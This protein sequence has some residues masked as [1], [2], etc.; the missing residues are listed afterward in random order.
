MPSGPRAPSVRPPV[1]L[2]TLALA[3]GMGTLAACGQKGPPLAPLLILPAPVTDLSV[4]RV[5]DRARLRFVLPDRNVEGAG[6]VAL[7][8]VEIFAVTLPPGVSG[9][10]DG[11][12]MV[13]EHLVGEIRVRPAPVEGEAPAAGETRPAPGEAVSFEEELTPARLVPVDPPR[14]ASAAKAAPSAGAANAGGAPTGEAPEV[15]KG[16]PPAEAAGT[17]AAPA[18]DVPAKEADTKAPQA[19]TAPVRV[20]IARGVTRG[21]R[22]GPP[23]ARVQLPI[24]PVPPAPRDVVTRVTESGISLTWTPP[25]EAPESAF[26][27]YPLHAPLQPVNPSPLAEPSFEHAGVTSGTEYCYR[28]RAIRLAGEVPIEGPPSE[29]VCVTPRDLFPPAAPRGLA[30]VSTPGQISLIWDAS[31][32]ADVA[33]YLVL[34]GEAP[35]GPLRPITPAPVKETSFRDTDVTPGTTYVYAVVAV[36][37]A[38]PPNTSAQSGRIEETAR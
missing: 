10:S 24:V 1:R 25:P 38:E 32:E 11:D 31:P 30:A 6:P 8:R 22:P 2:A 36:D 28:V 9:P 15:G 17:P 37:T 33:G 3:L 35:D 16:A 19:P 5:E 29:G 26:N 21:G 20:Y 27:V 14:G 18:P 23:S 7:D 34:R 12:L 4:R 13:K